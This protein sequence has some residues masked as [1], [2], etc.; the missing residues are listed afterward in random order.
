MTA[1]RGSFITLTALLTIELGVDQHVIVVGV[2]PHHVRGRGFRSVRER[3]ERSEVL[4]A[5][6]IADCRIEHGLC[7]IL[8]SGWSEIRVGSPAVDITMPQLG[9]TVT[10]GTVLRWCKQVG[11]RI[12]VDEAAARGVDRQ[13][14]RRGAVAGRG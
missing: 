4:A 14:R 13:G 3:G 5:R 1:T 7:P 11:E 2:D 8:R 12:G 10:E 6:E 9:E